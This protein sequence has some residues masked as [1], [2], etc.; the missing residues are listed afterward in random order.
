MIRRY[1]PGLRI[2]LM[3]LDAGSAV[4][5]AVVVFVLTPAQE[6][7][8]AAG[9]VDAPGLLL[10]FGLGWVWSL[11]AQDLYRFR[12]RWSARTEVLAVGRA[13]AVFAFAAV[14]VLDVLSLT[15]LA[16][17][18]LLALPALAIASI[19]MRAALRRAFREARRRGRNIRSVLVIGT[20]EPALAFDTK[21]AEHWELGLRV[22][23]F[24]GSGDNRSQ[25]GGRYFGE[26]DR[27]PAVLYERVIDEVAICLPSATRSEIDDLSEL[28][29]A[30]GK[31]VR[32]PTE[33]PE[34]MT[35][36][37]YVED[38]D[39]QPIVS[40]VTGPDRVMAL[41]MKRLIDIGGAT[42][43]LILLSPLFAVVAIAIGLTDGRPILF[44]Q[45][46]VGLHG[47]TFLV[48]KFRTM[49]KDADSQRAALRQY[50]EVSGNASFKM[51]DDPRVTRIGRVLRRT[52][53]D[54]L[55]QLWNVLRGE[56]SLVGP[57]PHPLDDVAGYDPWHRRRLTMKPGITG[58]WQIAGRREPDFDRW[59]RFDLE[60]IDHWSLWL[61]LR[62]LIRTIPAMLRAEGR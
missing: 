48:V 29:M 2:G 39:G 51:T 20:G 59:V 41:A 62:L 61:D 33:L 12:V 4:L 8:S 31:I 40:L 49:S 7:A 45:P 13:I 3:T 46:R 36:T 58:L 50:N 17:V 47:R 60:Y 6:P 32:I 34:Y 38:L 52:S 37:A 1:A 16:S 53:I 23:G 57:R 19:L 25:L 10:L 9:R 24:L 44:R 54:E 18:L 27:L 21:L 42:L 22:E 11:A 26:I 14:V 5:I 43:G 56:M 35:S 55:P 15:T 28:V 30:E